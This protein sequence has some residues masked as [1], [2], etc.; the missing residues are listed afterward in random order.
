MCAESLR[1]SWWPCFWWSSQRR[2]RFAHKRP[3]QRHLS[4]WA[5]TGATLRAEPNGASAA[6]AVVPADASVTMIEP[7]HRVVEQYGGRSGLRMARLGICQL[8]SCYRPA[9]HP[10]RPRS[11]RRRLL[12][13]VHRVCQPRLSERPR[14]SPKAPAR[15]RLQAR[16]RRAAASPP[17]APLPAAPPATARGLRRPPVA[18]TRRPPRPRQP[19]VPPLS[20]GAARTRRSRRSTRRRRRTAGGWGPGG[21]SSGSSR[22][23]VSR[24][25]RRPTGRPGRWPRRDQRPAGRGGGE[26]GARARSRRRWRRTVAGRTS[27][28]PSRTTCGARTD[29]ERSA[30]S[31]AVGP[32]KIG[33]P[34]AWDVT[35]GQP[36]TRIAI[37]DC[38]IYTESS[39]YKAPRR[40]AGHPD[41]RGKVVAE[42]NFSNATTGADDWCGHG[43][44]M[45]GIAAAK[46]EQRAVRHRWGGVQRQAA[47]RQGAGRHRRRARLLGGERDRLGGRQRRPGHQ[48][49]PG[50]R[51]CVLPDDAERRQL[52]LEHGRRGGGGGR[53][54]RRGRGR[55]PRRSARELQQRDRRW[56][57][58]TRT[59]AGPRSPTTGRPSRWPRRAS[60]ILSTN[61]I[62]TYSTVSGTSPATPHVA[63][64]A[65]LLAVDAAR[66]DPTRRS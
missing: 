37:L 57:R 3:P 28:G 59:T 11:P 24:T 58:S 20:G 55:D 49:E 60:N 53:Q 26:G 43:T 29:A 15:L 45:A 8:R 54:R 36:S 52:R 21:S 31:L 1:S 19:A 39:A 48:H 5:W 27:P 23:R 18:P 22:G 2:K 17:P 51:W 10:S 13:R 33:A 61:F 50:R 7:G 38:G 46:H 41:L 66:L 64:V 14:A 47:Q 32:Q 4:L 56:G 65:A 40:P 16:W 42:T 34:I 6:L 30:V 12:L 63:A 25:G 62:G 9:A 44:L 35:T